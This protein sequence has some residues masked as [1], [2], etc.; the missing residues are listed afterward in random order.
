MTRCS[1]QWRAIATN[2]AV[3]KVLSKQGDGSMKKFFTGLD[4]GL[5]RVFSLF[6]GVAMVLLTGV[7]FFQVIARYLLHISIGGLEELPVYLMAVSVWLAS[8]LVSRDDTHIRLD[9]LDLIVKNQKIRLLIKIILDALV[10]LLLCVFTYIMWNY[11]LDGISKGTISSGL[12]FPLWW[13]TAVIIFSCLLMILYT[14][15]CC[16]KK[17]REVRHGNLS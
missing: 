8:A 6:L 11:M 1:A 17:I 4:S 14:C 2:N 5:E 13:I 3:G 15:L 12:K 7:V 10:A 9:I 16:V